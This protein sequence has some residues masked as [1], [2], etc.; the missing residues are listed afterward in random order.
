M[1]SLRYERDRQRQGYRI[2]FHVERER[3]SL[4][5][6]DISDTKATNVKRNLEELI[7]A[8]KQACRPDALAVKWAI[9]VDSRIQKVLLKSGLLDDQTKR[10]IQAKQLK[11]ADYLESIISSKPN[12]SDSWR[13]NYGQARLGYSTGRV[14]QRINCLPT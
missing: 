12:V 4:W 6:G 11:L 9:A 8:K 13:I 7:E 14:C 1:A 2:Q 10:D 3:Y 5:L